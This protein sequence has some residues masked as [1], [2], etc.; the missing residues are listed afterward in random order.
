MF[1]PHR[2]VITLAICSTCFGE[3]ARKD[4][5]DNY[6]FDKMQRDGIPH[7]PLAS[8]TEFLRRVT[9]DLTGRLPTPEQV[10]SFLQDT[11]PNK[12]DKAIDSLISTLPTEGVSRRKE[13]P[14]L[15]RWT[16]FSDEQSLLTRSTGL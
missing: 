9:L 13:Q 5:V 6:I 14:F 4:F 8:D 11:D 16:F 7:V 1:V 2:F 3:I 10:R 15:D 12:R